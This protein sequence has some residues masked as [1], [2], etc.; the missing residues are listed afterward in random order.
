MRLINRFQCCSRQ[1]YEKRALI[2]SKYVPVCNKGTSLLG[3][4]KQQLKRQRAETDAQKVTPEEEELYCVG[5]YA[6]EQ[7]VQRGCGVFLTG[8]SQKPSGHN[9]IIWGPAW[10]QR[11]D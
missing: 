4:A 3:A 2:N 5:D 8:D 6:P 7:I 11:L 9:G 10:A 1:K